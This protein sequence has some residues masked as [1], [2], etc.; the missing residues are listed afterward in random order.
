M[1]TVNPR[2][3]PTKKTKKSDLDN[4]D[5]QI[6]ELKKQI[7]ELKTG[8]Q[9]TQADFENYRK[10]V[11]GERLENLAYAR[12]EFISQ[13]TPVLDNFYRAFSGTKKDD[14]TIQG[15]LQI[16]KQLEEILAEEGLEKIPA[17]PG[18]KFDP[19][20]HEAISSESHRTIAADCII[21]EVESGWMFQDKVLKPAKV[22][23]SK[24]EM[25][26]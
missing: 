22:R 11:E 13:L 21:A 9:R 14:P 10:R 1:P 17:K 16:K 26:S 5:N 25:G 3:K 6:I 15:F 4:R 18:N 20:L 12:A 7:E 2:R 23:V 19:R 24:G 8:W